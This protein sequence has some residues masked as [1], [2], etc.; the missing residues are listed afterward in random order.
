M[1]KKELYKEL[2]DVIDEYKDII[3][4]VSSVDC[5]GSLSEMVNLQERYT[6]EM[7]E[8]IERSF[9]YYI[10]PKIENGEIII[11]K[12]NYEDTELEQEERIEI[13]KSDYINLT[14]EEV[15]NFLTENE[16]KDLIKNLKS[17]MIGMKLYLKEKNKKEKIEKYQ[18]MGFKEPQMYEIE[19]G[20]EQG[21]DVSKYADPKFDEDQMEQIR[22]GLKQNLDVNVYADSK[23]NSKQMQEIRW[24]LEINVDVSKYANPKFDR[25][26]MY[27]I[28]RGL[29]IGIDISKYINPRE[30]EKSAKKKEPKMEI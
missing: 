25:W 6:E 20:L 19:L 5:D 24:G 11:N 29:E 16:F 26:H 22:K 2:E 18:E 17:E 8:F 14:F 27:E 10:I 1:D 21:L 3:Y 7:Y 4:D 15:I 9:D 28:R 13:E 30:V 23:F 12:E